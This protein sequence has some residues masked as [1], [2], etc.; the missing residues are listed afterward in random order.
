MARGSVPGIFLSGVADSRMPKVVTRSIAQVFS[1]RTGGR[2]GS[3]LA[4][5][6][7]TRMVV[8]PQPRSVRMSLKC[9]SWLFFS[10]S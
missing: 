9:T 5:W 2:A 7:A 4:N 3:S 1:V 8:N 6:L 10:I